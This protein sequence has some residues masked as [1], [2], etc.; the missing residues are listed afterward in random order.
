MDIGL[1]TES[2]R[3]CR[4]LAGET[5][6]HVVYG[7][8]PT[9]GQT[10]VFMLLD[11]ADA[12]GAAANAALRGAMRRP[13]WEAAA[14]LSDEAAEI[15]RT[16]GNDGQLQRCADACASFAEDWRSY[17]ARLD[18]QDRQTATTERP[19]PALKAPEDPALVEALEETFPASD[20]IAVPERSRS[21]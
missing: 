6:R 16:F 14:A 3:R 20:P 5:V 13:M 9:G 1:L 15:C 18:L 19:D 2:A 8:G 17:R 7:S 10:V 11:V 12:I 21:G 4:I